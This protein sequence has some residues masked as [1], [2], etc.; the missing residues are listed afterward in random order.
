MALAC[1][2]WN[3]PKLDILLYFGVSCKKIHVPQSL[4]CSFLLKQKWLEAIE[5]FNNKLTRLFKKNGTVK[6]KWQNFM[7]LEQSW[8][9]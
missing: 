6:K 4:R 9:V 2:W 5:C 3:T 8:K 7:S 1:E